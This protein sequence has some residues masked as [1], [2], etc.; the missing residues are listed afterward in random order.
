[1]KV[2]DTFVGIQQVLIHAKQQFVGIWVCH[3]QLIVAVWE[4]A[5]FGILGMFEDESD[6]GRSV[7]KGN[8]LDVVT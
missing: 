5:Q 2:S 7:Q 4:C 3:T 6:M 8:H 1:M